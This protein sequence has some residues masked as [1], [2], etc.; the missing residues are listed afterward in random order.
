MVG[1]NWQEAGLHIGGRALILKRFALARCA[2]G[3]RC[4]SEGFCL[5]ADP[6]LGETGQVWKRFSRQY[7][8]TS[9]FE[10]CF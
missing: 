8:Q 2:L 10:I 3:S 4:F 1:G 7:I 6:R 5:V 9:D